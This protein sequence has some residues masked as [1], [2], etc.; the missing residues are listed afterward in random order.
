MRPLIKNLRGDMILLIVG[1]C[2][3]GGLWLAATFGTGV[4]S[5]V[6]S[7]TA[8]LY[9]ATFYWLAL[10]MTA[11]HMF[12]THR[13][14]VFWL[15]MKTVGLMVFLGLGLSFYRDERLAFI[16]GLMALNAVFLAASYW[17]VKRGERTP[18]LL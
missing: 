1:L 10:V 7:F 15:F 16:I 5:R 12:Q 8:G 3:C 17:R 6:S 2:L 18:A 13:Q 11:A 4:H 9:V 14:G